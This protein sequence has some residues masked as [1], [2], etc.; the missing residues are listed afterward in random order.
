MKPVLT[1]LHRDLILEL[2]PDEDAES[3]REW[4][5]L[6]KMITWHRRYNLGDKH[7]FS[8]PETFEKMARS[9]KWLT[10]PLYLYDH[11]GLTMSTDGGRYPFNDRWDAGQ[12][13]YIYCTPKAGKKEYGVGWVEKARECM[14]GEV[15]AYD[16]FLQGDVYG[17]VIS[18]EV[19]CEKCQHT[20]KEVLDSCWGF[21][22]YDYA[23]VEARGA[24]QYQAGQ[25][26]KEEVKADDVQELS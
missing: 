7:E 22:G 4:D 21:L 5:N 12:V 6:G 20:E 17:Y 8:S 3:P 16:Q 26:Q 13:G 14:K 15:K 10:L 1:E 23:L 24:A 25:L 19:E 9:F 18:R 11:S 2:F